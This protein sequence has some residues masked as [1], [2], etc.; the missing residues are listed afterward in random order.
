MENKGTWVVFLGSDG[1]GKSTLINQLSFF[2]SK[3]YTGVN[4]YHFRPY[5]FSNK[6]PH[7]SSPVVN[8]HSLPARFSLFSY[9]KFLYF[10]FDYL[11][12]YF[13]VLRP[14]INNG[15]IVFFDRHL[16][17]VIVDPKRYRYNSS[18]NFIKFLYNLLPK[19]DLFFILNADPKII[20]NRKKET[21]LKT[22]KLQ[23][24]LYLN[25]KHDIS[26]SVL[27]FTNGS[28]RKSLSDI[29]KF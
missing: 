19:P 3:L 11:F 17:D 27:I 5:F 21:S 15:E 2:C 23:Q 7:L 18:I 9:L 6:N 1:S 22:I 20:Q 14:K 13:F 8:P 28:L 10:Y 16:I 4:Y 26:N 24:D 25:L 12:G 29:K